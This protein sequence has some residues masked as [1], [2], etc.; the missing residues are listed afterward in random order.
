MNWFKE[1][2]F[3]SGILAVALIGGGAL[4]YLIMQ[5]AGRLAESTDNY[6]AAVSRLHSLQNRVPFPNE[7]NLG[8]IRENLAAY[9][10]RIS[11]LRSQLSEMEHPL[12]LEITPQQFQDELR[13]AVNEL[14]TRATANGV[15]LPDDFYFGFSDYQA[16][17]P[18]PQAAPYLDRQLRVISSLVNRLVDFKVQSIDGLTRQPLPQEAGAAPVTPP[19][20]GRNR[21]NASESAP[22]L[23][24]FPF[25][26]SFTAEQGKLRVAF[27]SILGKEQFLI[28]RSMG[29]QNTN[30]EPPSRRA[31]PATTS[32]APNPFAA[33]ETPG[34]SAQTLQVILGR[35][36]VGVTLRLEMLD[37]LETPEP[38]N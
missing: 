37:F 33:A 22:V 1:N 6:S 4:G 14:R 28:V 13:S 23:E 34:T 12:N 24:R 15:A 3:V 7:E 32:S 20:E 10:K 38:K 35:E 30:P 36:L 26:I 2:P 21:P 11:T 16:Q 29:I 18:S 27:N 9:E 5:A 31:D 25:E 8:K 19:A 17:V